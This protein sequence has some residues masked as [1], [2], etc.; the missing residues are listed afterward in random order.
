M[1]Q[2]IANVTAGLFEPYDYEDLTVDATSGGV[3]LDSTK[4]RPSAGA[5]KNAQRVLLTLETAAIRYTTDGTAPTSSLGHLLNSGDIL[6]LLGQPSIDNFRAIRDTG[7][8]GTFRC[9]YER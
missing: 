6:V 3:G 8:T 9:T 4:V 5:L 2:N 1:S 7:T